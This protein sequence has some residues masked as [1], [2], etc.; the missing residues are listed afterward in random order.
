M[1]LIHHTPPIT[2][3]KIAEHVVTMR[4]SLKRWRYEETDVERRAQIALF[5]DVLGDIPEPI[6]EEAFRTWCRVNAHFPAPAELRALAV[7]MINVAKSRLALLRSSAPSTPQPV[8][9]ELTDE[10]KARRAAIAAEYGFPI[11]NGSITP[12]L[13]GMR[14]KPK[15]M[16][17]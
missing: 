6:A 16:E 10:E 7:N 15:E 14:S 9:S 2:S 17:E 4:G 1:A 12:Q 5:C 13:Q 11:V 8:Q 3:R